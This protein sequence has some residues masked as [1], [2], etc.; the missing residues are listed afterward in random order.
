MRPFTT[1]QKVYLCVSLSNKV[2]S[3]TIADF[4][5]SNSIFE[6]GINGTYTAARNCL[7]DSPWQRTNQQSC[8]RLSTGS[9]TPPSVAHS[10]SANTDVPAFDYRPA[11]TPPG[12]GLGTKWKV[13]RNFQIFSRVVPFHTPT[14]KELK[15][16][17]TT[18]S[19]QCSTVGPWFPP[20]RLLICISLAAKMAK[21]FSCA[22]WP[23]SYLSLKCLIKPF[24]HLKKFS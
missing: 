8:S 21:S 2:F 9:S 3:L 16:H 24:V 22:K 7:G 20:F 15:I 17:F 18:T 14:S 13:I 4:Y 1:P 5:Q 12:I 23:F 6:L 11:R 10:S 19:G